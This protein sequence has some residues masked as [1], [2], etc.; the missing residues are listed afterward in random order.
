MADSGLGQGKYKVT[1]EHLVMPERKEVLRKQKDASMSK[2]H[3][4]QAERAPA[5]AG[6]IGAIT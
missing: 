5:K 3:S 4:S 6:T 2:E 1:L